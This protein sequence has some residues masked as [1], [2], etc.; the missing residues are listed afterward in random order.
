MHYR[1]V[2]AIARIRFTMSPRAS[3]YKFHDVAARLRLQPGRSRLLGE[4]RQR[5]VSLARAADR[6]P[7]VASALR[8]RPSL[9]VDEQLL[10]ELQRLAFL[11]AVDDGLEPRGRRPVDDSDARRPFDHE[12]LVRLQERAELAR[13]EWQ[14]LL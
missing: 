11:G 2:A 6:S 4:R 5:V 3:A 13:H 14:S 10:L 12:L 9:L 7:L 1:T 8:L